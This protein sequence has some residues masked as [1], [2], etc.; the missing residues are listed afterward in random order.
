MMPRKGRRPEI[1]FSRTAGIRGASPPS[2]EAGG[3]YEDRRSDTETQEVRARKRV[4]IATDMAGAGL[5]KRQG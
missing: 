1:G 5:N 2:S 3:R 4:V